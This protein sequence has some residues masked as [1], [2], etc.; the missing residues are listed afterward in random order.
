MHDLARSR[1]STPWEETADVLVAGA[2]RRSRLSLSRRPPARAPRLV[3]GLLGG[4]RPH[5]KVLRRQ[6]LHGDETRKPV[7]RGLELSPTF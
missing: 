3:E 2:Q 4:S 6:H 5:R 7:E 1:L